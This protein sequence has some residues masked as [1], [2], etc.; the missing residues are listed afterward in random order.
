VER[1][2]AAGSGAGRDEAEGRGRGGACQ[3]HGLLSV[4]VWVFCFGVNWMDGWV[5]ELE[6][7]M[8]EDG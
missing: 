6:L 5:E 2:V 3:R 1:A 7:M 4:G 8:G